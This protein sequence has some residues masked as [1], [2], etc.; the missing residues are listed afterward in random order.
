MAAYRFTSC[1]LRVDYLYIHRDQ[2]PAQRSV[3]SMGQLDLLPFSFLV[4]NVKRMS[5][6]CYEKIGRV[7]CVTRML[8]GNRSRGISALP[9]VGFTQ[10]SC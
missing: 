2:L 9:D 5:L 10:Q 3:T 1:N 8:R 6:I 4:A 7:G